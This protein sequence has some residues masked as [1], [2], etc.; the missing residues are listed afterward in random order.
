[1]SRIWDWWAVSWDEI[2]VVEGGLCGGCV[3]GYGKEGEN[4]CGKGWDIHIGR[5]MIAAWRACE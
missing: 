5:C 3:C 4:V 1:V 2:F